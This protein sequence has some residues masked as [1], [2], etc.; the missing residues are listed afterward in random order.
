MRVF[1]WGGGFRGLG[2]RGAIIC[3][4]FEGGDC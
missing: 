2:S 4:F 3:V 1:F